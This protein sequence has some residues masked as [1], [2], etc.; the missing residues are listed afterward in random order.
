MVRDPL[1]GH[2]G[3]HISEQGAAVPSGSMVEGV[4]RMVGSLGRAELVCQGEQMYE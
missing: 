3:D 4:T 2:D 1:H